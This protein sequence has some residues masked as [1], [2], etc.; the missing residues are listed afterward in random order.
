MKA[1]SKG[2]TLELTFEEASALYHLAGKM[3]IYNM[4]YTYGLTEAEGRQIQA[5]YSTLQPLLDISPDEE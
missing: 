1:T 4:Q 3:T 5:I 2:V